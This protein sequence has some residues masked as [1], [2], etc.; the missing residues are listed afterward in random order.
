MISELTGKV[1]RVNGPSRGIGQAIVIAL[2]PAEVDVAVTP[3]AKT[4]RRRSVLRNSRLIQ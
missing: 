4:K 3:R 2:V 1:T